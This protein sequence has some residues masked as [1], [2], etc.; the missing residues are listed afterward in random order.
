MTEKFWKGVKPV[1]Y[2]CV[3]AVGVVLLTLYIAFVVNSIDIE[4]YSA[5]DS[6]MYSKGWDTRCWMSFDP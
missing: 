3:Y 2:L 6:S 5:P 1:V 4:C